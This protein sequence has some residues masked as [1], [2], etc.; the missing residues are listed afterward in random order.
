MAPRWV[1]QQLG[2]NFSQIIWKWLR[3]SLKGKSWNVLKTN[4]FS[5]DKTFINVFSRWNLV[6]LIAISFKKSQIV[7]GINS[8]SKVKSAHANFSL[9]KILRKSLRKRSA[10]IVNL[11]SDA[12]PPNPNWGCVSGTS[13]FHLSSQKKHMNYMHQPGK[14]ERNGSK[15]SAQSL[16]W[17]LSQLVSTLCLH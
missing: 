4:Q 3:L 15:S 6:R 17:I 7:I 8:M 12:C 14:K 5:T 16:I 10:K 9:T 2:R 1:S 11:F 13:D